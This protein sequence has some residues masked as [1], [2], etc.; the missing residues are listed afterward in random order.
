MPYAHAF[1][2]ERT[3]SLK[4]IEYNSIQNFHKAKVLT[5]DRHYAVATRAREKNER[6]R[7]ERKRV[8]ECIKR[9]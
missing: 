2:Q 9:C 5:K 7:K 8:Q 3:N 1:K 6:G 4:C